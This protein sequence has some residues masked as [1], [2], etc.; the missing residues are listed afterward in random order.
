MSSQASAGAGNARGARPEGLRL[1]PNFIQTKKLL[2][3]RQ[4]DFLESALNV[5]RETLIY[6][7]KTARS[8]SAPKVLYCGG[9]LAQMQGN[10][11]RKV[12]PNRTRIV[13]KT[14]E[15]RSAFGIIA[16]DTEHCRRLL[17]LGE[18]SKPPIYQSITNILHRSR[19]VC[20]GLVNA[21]DIVVWPWYRL[22]D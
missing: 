10:V 11:T 7:C 13:P 12:V 15:L 19:E 1:R 17:E 6:R 3:V 2:L 4:S 5:L 18:P 20:A 8:L 16:E 14:E 21:P 9:E 22:A